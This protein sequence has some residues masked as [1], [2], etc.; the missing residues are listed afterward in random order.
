MSQTNPRLVIDLDEIE[1]QLTQAQNGGP[2]APKQDPLAELARIVGQDDPFRTILSDRPQARPAQGGRPSH[3]Y[4][5]P[6]DDEPPVRQLVYRAEQYAHEPVRRAEPAY[7]EPEAEPAAHHDEAH[8]AYASARDDVR[9]LQRSRSRK[10]LITVLAVLAAAVIGVAGAL[11]LRGTGALRG[12]EPPIVTAGNDPLKVRPADPGGVEIPNQNKQIYERGAE[13]QTRVVN[14]EEQPV[15]V[16]QAVRAAAP[17]PAPAAPPANGA[18]A[19]TDWRTSTGCSSRLTTR[20]WPS[21][22]RS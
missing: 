9:S 1:R 21:A 4:P 17:P 13:G 7:E 20:V 10:G 16:R 19:R 3:L 2:A 11:T 8:P 14:R 6:N 12:G 22:P 15:D 18:A 5:V